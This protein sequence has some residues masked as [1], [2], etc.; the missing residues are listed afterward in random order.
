MNRK[1]AKRILSSYVVAAMS[2]AGTMPA[3]ASGQLPPTPIPPR[4]F[5]SFAEC[6]AFLEKSYEQDR[7]RA[8]PNPVAREDGTAQ[9]LIRS[10]GPV[11][12]DA[13]HATYEV[14]EGWQFR[15]RDEPERRII[16]SY[17][18][19]ATRMQCDGGELTGEKIKGYA[20]NGIEPLPNET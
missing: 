15:R 9:T 19:E 4:S 17:S 14:E 13:S 16:T 11:I 5:I 18:Y 10:K 2:I 20:M 1:T 6:T 8:D 7:S 3:L 12:T